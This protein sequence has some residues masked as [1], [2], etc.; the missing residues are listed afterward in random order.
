ML[1][2]PAYVG[3]CLRGRKVKESPH[4]IKTEDGVGVA[5]IAKCFALLARCNKKHVKRIPAPRLAFV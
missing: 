2:F 1:M 4:E 3:V 5:I